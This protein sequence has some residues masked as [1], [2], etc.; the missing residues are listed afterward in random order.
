M[1]TLPSNAVDNYPLEEIM[2]VIANYP[3][4][5]VYNM[6]EIGLY[7]RCLPNRSYFFT[8][9]APNGVQGSK[10]MKIRIG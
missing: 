4:F 5:N 10:L 2:L 9:K 6:D 8:D 7:Y 1:S 3:T